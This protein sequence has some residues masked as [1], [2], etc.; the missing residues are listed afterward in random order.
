M[1]E[2]LACPRGSAAIN[3]RGWNLL[4]HLR[5]QGQVKGTGAAGWGWGRHWPAASLTLPPCMAASPFSWALAQ[6]LWRPSTTQGAGNH[7]FC[8]LLPSPMAVSFQGPVFSSLPGVLATHQ[9]EWLNWAPAP[10]SEIYNDAVKMARDRKTNKQ[11]EKKT[12]C[13]TVKLQPLHPKAEST[14]GESIGG[15]HAHICSF[16]QCFACLLRVWCCSRY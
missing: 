15:S 5:S 2:P 4:I 3:P 8:L 7:T 16:N 10:S 1:Q 11:T 13:G 12:T 9:E 14:E 6:C